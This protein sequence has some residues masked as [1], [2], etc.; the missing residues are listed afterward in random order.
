MRDRTADGL[1]ENAS[2][3]CGQGLIGITEKA[4]LRSVP[5]GGMFLEGIPMPLRLFKTKR[6]ALEASRAWITDEELQE[7]FHQMLQGQADDLGGGVWKKRLK[8]N[9]HRSIV[10]AKGGH[11]WIYQVLF[12]KQDQ[13]NITPT[14]LKD[15][16]KLAKV[17]AQLTEEQISDLLAM[18]EFVEICHE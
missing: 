9:R 14:E 17:Y 18:K 4:V 8:A 5:L 13:S 12:A 7:A 11:Y 2:K 1:L 6:F 10:L 3:G 16:R 15:L